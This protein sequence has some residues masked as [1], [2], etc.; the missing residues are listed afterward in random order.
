[1]N[2]P[3]LN[4]RPYVLVA[5]ALLLVTPSVRAQTAPASPAPAAAG[6]TSAKTED[7]VK[8]EA[9]TVTGSNLK[10]LEM[11]KVLPVTVFSKDLIDGRN[12][13]TPVELLTALPQVTNVPLNESTSGGANSRGDNANINL[14]G[15]GTG[16][17]LVLLNGRRVAPHPVFSPDGSNPNSFSVNVNQLPTQG[18]ERIDVLRDGAS[19]IY[20][21]DAVAGVIN[22]LTR[23]DFRG[24]ELRTRLGLPEHG[25]G[26]SIQ[27][28]LTH[29]RDFNGG[30]GRWLSTLDYLY[31]WPIKFTQRDY[32]KSADHRAQAAAFV[33]AFPTAFD[34]RSIL[35]V[36]PRFTVGTGT[37]NNYFRPV[38]GTPTL[39]TSAPTLAANPEAAI[40]IN[41]FQNLG[42]TRSDRINW[43]NALE[44]DL[45]DRITA[46]G[47]FSFYH[48]NSNLTRQ[49][50]P[51]NAPGSDQP[52]PMSVDNPFNPYGSRYYHPTGAPN[53]DGTPRL[54]GPPQRIVLTGLTL[55]EAGGEDIVVHSG[56]YRGV[57]GLRGKV[58]DEWNWEVGA[59]YT[60]AY[61]SDISKNAVRESAL[62]QALMRTD[63]TAF[64]P[65]R[66][67][68]RVVPGATAPVA[69][70]PYANP[71]SVMDSF[72][73]IWRHDGFSS[74]GSGDLR[75]S[76]PVLRYWGNTLSVAGG[77]E[78]R[79]ETFTDY[80]PPYAGT[81]PAGSGLSL[82][83]NDFIQ[84][85][86]KFNFGGDRTVYSAYLE[87]VIP[88]T[89]PKHDLPALHSLELTASA[90]YENY[91]DFGTTTKP[92]FGANWRPYRG[93][94][95]RAS[96]NEG[97]AAANLPTLYQPAQFTVDS[98]PG[99]TDPYRNAAIN[100]GAYVQ[101]NYTSGNKDLLPV[102]ST[103][104]S[105]GIVLEIPFV[106]GL[107]VTADYW[108][109]E[110]ENEISIRSA[111]Q[112]LNRDSQLLRDYVNAQLAAGRTI[113]QID[114]GSGT[115]NYR[116]DP[117]VVRFA[118]TPEDVAAFNA[119]NA[120]KPA[121]QQ[122]PV[123]GRI[124]SRTAKFENL[125]QG[126]SSGIDMSL[127]Y[128]LPAL[129]VGR[130]T[131][132]TEWSYLIESNQTRTPPG[133]TPQYI[134]RMNVG[135]TTRWRGT[136]TITWRKDQWN[137]SLSAYYV[138]SWADTAT[139]TAALY[140]SLGEPS[141]V[142]KQF[143]S[144]GFLYRFRVRDVT[145]FNAAL[146]YRF[147]REAKH[148]FRGTG[149][150]L[151]VINLT[152]REPPLVPGA[153]GY[154]SSVH[155]SLFAGRTWTLEITRQF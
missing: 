38:N 20:G 111:S 48:S 99:Q 60:R 39:T 141:Y 78:Y 96:Y 26:Q 114:L 29:G 13:L 150:R 52:A 100:E 121:A 45:T 86:P 91:S 102:E 118:V 68:F 105:A 88:L 56:V 49:P 106:K 25:A 72:V 84:A 41:V 95:V 57:A 138:G 126:Y 75:V 132:S 70:Q 51:I 77:G 69:D 23:R 54:T 55:I 16:N 144:G 22:Y 58:F 107:S 21:S 92:K 7:A 50:I 46:F 122:L 74:I 34:G 124:F 131:V 42:Q 1:M 94:M 153:F 147:Q 2:Q 80:R 53:A 119:A 71:K 76:G 136:G 127:N 37:A 6:T 125:A 36:W 109:I 62:Q 146:G 31:R 10:R 47:D 93:L 19:S 11:E 12:A 14:R 17:T 135:G 129:P 101:R 134:E 83:D 103:G 108:E 66:Y 30:K 143:D 28:T 81:N 33:A 116:G 117:N 4:L 139:T 61:T 113:S 82:D 152:D 24:T 112:I 32:T 5:S 98:L 130:F 15:I 90:R 123:V 18:L 44:Y 73:Q 35:G 154:S 120:S 59:L 85:S 128:L 43:F 97:F 140:N 155:G 40:D 65:F 149:V 148:L 64:N 115:A 133:G 3:R 104:K 79:K 27:A 151:G 110:Q 142:S 137:A 63:S 67:T 89:Q 87:T 8:L 9:F 145:T